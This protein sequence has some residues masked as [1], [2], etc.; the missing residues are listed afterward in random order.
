M[1]FILAFF[2]KLDAAVQRRFDSVCFFLMR[3]FG[4]KKSLIRYVLLATIVMAAFAAFAAAFSWGKREPLRFI[5]DAAF[6]LMYLVDQWRSK[7]SD[8]EAEARPCTVSRTDDVPGM[9]IDAFKIVSAH[10]LVMGIAGFETPS[11]EEV[12]LRWD[13]S[14]ITFVHSMG[15]IWWSTFLLT[16]YLRRTP[17]N[18]PPESVRESAFSP[19]PAPAKL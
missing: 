1:G 12:R 9:I 14:Q 18:P 3:R 6:I 13:R 10:L 4:V 2:S 17:M 11:T 16:C 8:E 19:R 15:L 5:I 7:R